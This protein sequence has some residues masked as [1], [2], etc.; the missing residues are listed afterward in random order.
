VPENTFA[1]PRTLGRF[2]ARSDFHP[3]TR[4]DPLA[5]RGSEEALPQ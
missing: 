2:S 1:S 4:T 5:P 3:A